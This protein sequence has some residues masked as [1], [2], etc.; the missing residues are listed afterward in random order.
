VDP[1]SRKRLIFLIRIISWIFS[2][3]AVLSLSLRYF[4]ARFDMNRGGNHIPLPSDV[5]ALTSP[6]YAWWLYL[7]V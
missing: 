7:C 5:K 6:E 2:V 1:S 3:V 4:M